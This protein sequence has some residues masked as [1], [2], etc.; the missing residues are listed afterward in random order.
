[1]PLIL[2]L[3]IIAFT[4]NAVQIPDGCTKIVYAANPNYA[5]F[6]CA[7]GDRYEGASVELL[8]HVIPEGI[9]LVPAVF[10][11]KRILVMA[12]EGEIDLILSLRQ[13]SERSEYLAYTPERSFSNPSVVF[14]RNDKMFP[15]NKWSDLKGLKGLISLGDT[16]G[17]GFDEYR[18]KELNISESG[19]AIENFKLLSEGKADYFI[20]GS[21]SG[22]EYLIRTQL[23]NNIVAIDKPIVSS[24][25]FFAFSRRS[26]CAPLVDYVSSQLKKLEDEGVTREIL[27][28][29]LNKGQNVHVN[30]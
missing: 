16:F 20:T 25:I 14:V 23:H 28:K 30:K 11:W 10:P 24:D 27:N 7:N 9:S 26:P 1:V 12:I 15:Y 13:T 5:P 19:S 17:G 8:Q 29:Y 2:I 4:A 3:C 22:A 18:K 21:N 6:H